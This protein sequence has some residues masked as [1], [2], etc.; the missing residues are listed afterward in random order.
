ML[1]RVPVDGYGELCHA[2]DVR[3]ADF[4]ISEAG[5][6]NRNGFKQAFSLHVDGVQQAMT[7]VIGDPPAGT[8]HGKIY[9]AALRLLFAL[10]A[11]V[12]DAT[13][14]GDLIPRNLDEFAR[15]RALARHKT[16][17]CGWGHKRIH[18]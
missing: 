17:S 10:L 5:Y 1:R 13:E 15:R 6:G 18:A 16:R 9:S 2:V 14:S 11:F 12:K 3:R 4:I 8:G 7:I